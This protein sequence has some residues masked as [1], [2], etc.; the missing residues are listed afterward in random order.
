ME[1][2]KRDTR[3]PITNTLDVLGDRWSLVVVRDLMFRGKRHFT[4]LLASEEGISTNILSDRLKRLE[5]E[6]LI[7]Q[8][9]DPTSRA[10]LVYRLTQKGKDLLP[11]LLEIIAWA[12]KHVDAAQPPGAFMKRLATDRKR[13]EREILAALD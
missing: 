12:G 13:L 6:G 2:P 7:D 9:P 10:K 1:R 11:V 5:A 3:C 4:E 8:S